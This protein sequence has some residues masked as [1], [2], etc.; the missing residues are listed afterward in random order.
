[1]QEEIRSITT[2]DGT[3]SVLVKSPDGDGPFPVVVM[4]H[5]GPG[6]RPSTHEVAR[7]VAEAGY[8]VA[9]PDRYYRR[10]QCF[11]IEP[12]DLVLAVSACIAAYEG[13]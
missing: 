1:M 9:V 6:V 8:L 12:E 7:R 10:A 3:Q 5:D 11:H 2:P 4:Y 13:L